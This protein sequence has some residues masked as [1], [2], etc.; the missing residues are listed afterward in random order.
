MTVVYIPGANRA[1][2][3][4]GDFPIVN[5]KADSK[6]RYFEFAIE[7]VLFQFQYVHRIDRRVVIGEYYPRLFVYACR[8]GALLY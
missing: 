5:S 8:A 3:K 4:A 7:T 2:Q 1:A 6:Y